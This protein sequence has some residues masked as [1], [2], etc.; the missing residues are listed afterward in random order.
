MFKIAV[1]DVDADEQTILANAFDKAKRFDV[2]YYSKPLDRRVSS[3]LQEIEGIAIFVRPAVTPQILD[4]LP[5][6]KIISTMSTGFD[7]IDL[8]ACRSRNITVCN[9]P[10]YGDNTVAEYAF[11]LMLALVRKLKPTFDR[12]ERGVFSRAGLMGQDLKGKTLGLI[13]VGR[14]GSHMARFGWAFEMKVIAHDRRISPDL[15]QKYGVTFF[16]LES[17]LQEADI[18]SLHVP[19]NPSTH[20][21]INEERLSLFKPTAFLVNTSRGKVVDT[22]AVS[23]ALSQGRIAGAALD[24]FEGE[25]IWFEEDFIKRDDLSAAAF[26]E[27]LESFSI[28]RSEAAI[29]T[30]HNAF[31]T[32]EALERILLTTVDNFN[33]Y[34]K[35]QPQNEVTLQI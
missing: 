8:D 23:I 12:A 20:H 1:F 7:H 6:L 17:V 14:I 9:V 30:P 24:T 28:M 16:D 31:N 19:Y 11:G 10:F 3:I 26:K 29:L 25:E 2:V 13:G 32:Q 34:V 18:V 21:L 15:V 27:A 35:G 5:K 22:K 4:F 33:A